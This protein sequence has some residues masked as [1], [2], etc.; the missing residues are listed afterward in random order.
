M[1]SEDFNIG[2]VSEKYRETK[3]KEADESDNSIEIKMSDIQKLKQKIERRLSEEDGTE[4]RLSEVL[5][6]VLSENDYKKVELIVLYLEKNKSITPKVAENITGRSG[7]TVRRYL[8][9]LVETG[10]VKAEGNTS[11]I[12]YVV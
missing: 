8:K 1:A 6:G 2:E 10:Y 7:A 5:S 4:R 11:N 12:R 9:I 3:S